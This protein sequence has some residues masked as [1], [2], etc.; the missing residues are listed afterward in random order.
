MA[1]AR[2]NGGGA[3]A[4]GNRLQRPISAGSMVTA[5][6]LRLASPPRRTNNRSQEKYP[7]HAARQWV[8]RSD[9]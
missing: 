3:L 1:V 2:P 7:C 5:T 6:P 8:E 4:G 9:Y